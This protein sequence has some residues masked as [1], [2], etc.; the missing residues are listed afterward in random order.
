M[1]G[2][3][4]AIISFMANA[5]FNRDAV[6]LLVPIVVGVALAAVGLIR[7]A[8]AP[9]GQS[10]GILL[11]WVGLAVIVIANVISITAWGRKRSKQQSKHR[12]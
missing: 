11:L 10:P 5:R 2:L 7:D 1:A 4:H 9:S 12:F 3:V 8:K 6:Y